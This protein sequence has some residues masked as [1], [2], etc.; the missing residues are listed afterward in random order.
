MPPSQLSSLLF[1]HPPHP[2]TL[3]TCPLAVAGARVTQP[4]AEWQGA[5]MEE[6]LGAFDAVREKHAAMAADEFNDDGIYQ[7]GIN[8]VPGVGDDWVHVGW[9]LAGSL[10]VVPACA[11]VIVGW[12]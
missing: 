4:S 12:W 2:T 7:A 6:L 5:G 11:G 8:Q 10:A 9:G 1:L 3:P